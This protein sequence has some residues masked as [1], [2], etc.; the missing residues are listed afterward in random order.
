MLY[1]GATIHADGKYGC[2][3]SRRIGMA[4][5]TFNSLQAVWKNS[6]INTARKLLFDALVASKLTYAVASAWLTKSDQRKLDGFHA[7]CLRRNF[8]IPAAYVS[9][10]SNEKVRTRAGVRPLSERAVTAQIELMEKVMTHPSKNVLQRVAFRN[11]GGTLVSATCHYTRTVGRPRQNWTDNVL[12][13]MAK[14]RSTN[15]L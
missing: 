9:R 8:R 6:A 7:R 4:T 12:D 15:K 13:L 10:V 5:S 2:E 3:L 14:R 1:L 11:V